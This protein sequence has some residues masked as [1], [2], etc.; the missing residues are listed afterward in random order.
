MTVTTQ[1]MKF[2]VMSALLVVVILYILFV[3]TFSNRLTFGLSIW[4]RENVNNALFFSKSSEARAI[5]LLNEVCLPLSD[6]S[7]SPSSPSS[8]E[9]SNP[10]FNTRRN[11]YLNQW[12]SPTCATPLCAQALASYK[13]V[14]P[15]KTSKFPTI[16]SYDEKM[17]VEKTFCVG[18]EAVSEA[19]LSDKFN[20]LSKLGVGDNLF[21]YWT[22]FLQKLRKLGKPPM[23]KNG[24][25]PIAVK[26]GDDKR[27]V[28][29]PL[30]RKTRYANSNSVILFKMGGWRHWVGLPDIVIGGERAKRSSLA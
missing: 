4:Q 5:Q 21:L 20:L 17:H 15:G 16:T 23:N 25:S 26:F 7:S 1:N 3:C 8:S 28:N 2:R 29:L 24:P 22:E 27:D 6:T 11:F 9:F 30:L 14:K 13:E 18:W 10:N 12:A 19:P